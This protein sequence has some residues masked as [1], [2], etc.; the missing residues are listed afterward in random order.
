M[1][2]NISRKLLGF[3]IICDQLKNSWDHQW[4]KKSLS[5]KFV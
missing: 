2:L 3:G 1:K 4:F 5:E